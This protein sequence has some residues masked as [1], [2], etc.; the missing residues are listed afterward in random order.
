MDFNHFLQNPK[1]K[2]Q[3]INPVG[4]ACAEQSPVLVI[5]GAPGVEE[6]RTHPYL[7]HVVHRGTTDTQRRIFSEICIETGELNSTRTACQE[8][9]KVLD[10]MMAWS[11]PGYIE[12]PR[13][14][15]TRLLSSPMPSYHPEKNITDLDKLSDLHRSHGLEVLDWMRK[16]SRPVVLAGVEVQRFGLQHMLL[17][18]LAREGWSCATSLSGKSLLGETNP[19]FLGIYN[20]AMSMENVK[21]QVE[22]SDGILV[23]GAHNADLDTGIWTV[24]LDLNKTVYV[25]MKVGLIW[26]AGTN[27]DILNTVS[28][29]KVWMEADPP[30]TLCPRRPSLA[31]KKHEP[32]QAK[33]DERITIRR[34]V[35]AVGNVVDENT[36]I[37]ADPG[38]ALFSAADIHVPF[39]NQFLTSGF[40]ASLGFALPA[41]LGAYYSNPE[42]NRPIV[43]V[44]DGAFLMCATE[45]ATLVRYN[46]PSLII[47]LDNKGYN[48]ERPM[49]DGSFNDVHP[50]NHVALATSFGIKR[51]K[52]VV[53][54]IEFWTCLQEFSRETSAPS[55]ISVS[56]D[57]SDMS[58]ALKHLTAALKKSV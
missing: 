56:I 3:V 57:P 7:H 19:H 45:L 30:Q 48:T 2:I 23:I 28:L 10:A 51:A 14:K 1:N 36:V 22:E 8:I 29:L 53:T 49:L 35:E 21:R 6:A 13:D 20:G 24:N 27:S 4:G 42:S 38:D 43:I 46:V 33:H 44:G 31:P 40:W 25:D 47:I 18:I 54:E 34:L 11:L 41:S 37:L 15:I 17:S 50:V 26:R 52:R 55:L 39:P 5:S 58:D 12:V 9:T 32:F 16:C